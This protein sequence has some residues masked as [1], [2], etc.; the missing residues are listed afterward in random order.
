MSWLGETQGRHLRAPCGAC[1]ERGFLCQADI[2]YAWAYRGTAIFLFRQA[3]QVAG[4]CGRLARVRRSRSR[5]RGNCCSRSRRSCGPFAYVL[6]LQLPSGH[7]N[8]AKGQ[9]P[10]HS[11][12][13]QPQLQLMA[14]SSRLQPEYYSISCPLESTN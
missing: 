5:S 11:Y 13:P 10:T 8:R 2:G 6:C 7:G 9:S 3:E 4:F 12:Y 14:S 1:Q